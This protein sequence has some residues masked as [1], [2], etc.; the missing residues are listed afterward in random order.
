M[1]EHHPNISDIYLSEGVIVKVARLILRYHE[2][3]S[4]CINQ[5]TYHKVKIGENQQA[6]MLGF[7]VDSDGDMEMESSQ[8]IYEFISAPKLVAWNR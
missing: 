6:S 2:L 7:K 5:A 4:F 8:P 1:Y 3:R